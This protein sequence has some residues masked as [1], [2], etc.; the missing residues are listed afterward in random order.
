MARTTGKVALR[1]K[2]ADKTIDAIKAVDKAADA[3]KAADKVADV[4]KAADK[5][6]DTLGYADKLKL[7]KKLPQLSKEKRDDIMELGDWAL[8]ACIT[9]WVYQENGK[10]FEQGLANGLVSG[11]PKMMYEVVIKQGDNSGNSKT[12]S[13]I[14]MLCDTFGS[15]LGSLT[16]DFFSGKGELTPEELATNAA[17]AAAEGL[18]YSGTSEFIDYAIEMADKADSVAR[19]LMNYDTGFGICLKIFFQKLIVIVSAFKS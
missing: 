1:L 15:V 18:V 19:K 8:D 14:K 17:I 7:L 10:P 11:L 16:D 9:G 13:A 12:D 6:I 2:K 4:A 3:A 5:A